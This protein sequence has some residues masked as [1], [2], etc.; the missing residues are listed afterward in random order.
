MSKLT[1]IDKR[2]KRD[3]KTLEEVENDSSYTD[4]QR[5]FQRDRLGDLN[6]EKQARLELLSQNRKD[7][8]IQAARIKQTLENVRDKNMPYPERIPFLIREQIVTIIL[9][10]SGLLTG[11]ATI[12]L[13]AIGAFGEAVGQEAF[14]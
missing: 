8:Q 2:I 9:T 10:L 5:Q 7:L 11:I 3:T 12:V 6:T 14:Y 4:E 13:S 1:E